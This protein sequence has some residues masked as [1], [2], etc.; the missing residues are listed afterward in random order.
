MGLDRQIEQARAEWQQR[1]VVGPI[2]LRWDSLPPQVGDDA[3]DLE[4]RDQEGKPRLLSEFWSTGPALLLFWRHNG[5][6]CG[7][8]RAARLNKEYEKYVS[9]GA[10]VLII[11]QAEPQRASVYAQKHGLPCP[12]LCDPDMVSYKAFGLREG[13]AGQVVY[14]APEEY[15]ANDLDTWASVAEERQVLGRPLV[16][17]PWQLPGEFVVDQKGK[18]RLSYHYNYCENYPDP[19]VLVASIKLAGL[20]PPI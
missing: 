15:W 8:D 4:L 12:T 16:D 9:A 18:L 19:Q 2:A 5:C 1:F 6:S 13:S 11:S 3:P 17:N 20:N 10:R 14:D 7:F